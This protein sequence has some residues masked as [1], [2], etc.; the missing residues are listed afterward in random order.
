MKAAL[1]QLLCFDERL[2]RLLLLAT[3]KLGSVM[4][5]PGPA[6]TTG[7]TGGRKGVLIAPV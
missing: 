5:L 2:L 7:A 6:A 3:P 4:R 1:L